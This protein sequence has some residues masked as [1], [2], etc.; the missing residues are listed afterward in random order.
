MSHRDHLD[1]IVQNSD[2]DEIFVCE[3]CGSP[4]VIATSWT[5]VNTLDFVDW[6]DLSCPEYYCNGCQSHTD[7]IFMS[8]FE[9]IKEGEV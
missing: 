1:E 3:K 7:V 5:N 9:E 4:D 8:E 6:L 2:P